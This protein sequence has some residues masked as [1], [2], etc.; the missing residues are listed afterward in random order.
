MRFQHLQRLLITLDLLFQQPAV[1][2]VEVA[3]MRFSVIARQR[4]VRHRLRYAAHSAPDGAVVP[5]NQRRQQRA[6][7]SVI[8]RSWPLPW[9]TESCCCSASITV[10]RPVQDGGHSVKYFTNAESYAY[11]PVASAPRE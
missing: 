10:F 7:S 5:D 3:K 4:S 8:R 2:L 6:F 1:V 11:L 9:P